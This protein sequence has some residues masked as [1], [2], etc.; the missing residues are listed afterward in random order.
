MAFGRVYLIGAGS[1]AADLISIRGRRALRSADAMLVDRLLP[2]DFLAE[3]GIPTADKLVEWL[4]DKSPRWSQSKINGWLTIQARRGRNVARLKGGDPF[5][6]GQAEEET[7]HLSKLGVPWEVIPGPS[8]FTAALTAAGFPL[9]RRHEGRGFSVSTARVAGG[10]VSG[11]FPKSDSLVI[12]MGVGV[13]DQIVAR[14]LADGWPADTQTAIIERGTLAWERRVLSPLARLA[15]AAENAGVSSPAC[16]I[17][18]SAATPIFASRQRPTILFTGL[19]PSNFRMLGNLLHWP[20]LELAANPEAQDTLPGVLFSLANREFDWVLFAGKVGVISFFQELDKRKLDSRALAVA[21]VATIGA[22]TADR[23]C[24]HGIRPDLIAENRTPEETLGSFGGLAGKSVLVVEGTHSPRRLHDGLM[25]R[26]ATVSSLALN[27]VVPNRQ[28]G[29]ALPDH[30]VICFVSPSGVRAYCDT[31]GPAVFQNR[32][33]CLGEDTQR[34][35]MGFG[36]EARVLMNG[37]FATSSAL[38]SA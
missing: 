2:R 27:C 22:G 11:H 17:V 20:A 18:G 19:D 15:A 9:T 25:D 10:A 5:V 24:E 21:S 34:E 23:L 14:L 32:V 28:L 37:K 12:M 16:V 31:Y 13:L 4:A 7:G 1:G 33:W 36:V 30:D 38:V 29:R 6:F 26:G 3:L 8:S 35:L